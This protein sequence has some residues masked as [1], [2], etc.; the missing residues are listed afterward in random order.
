M[1]CI[2]NWELEKSDYD[3]YH[4]NA[5]WSYLSH[6]TCKMAREKNKPDIIS[7][8]GVVKCD[9][10]FIVVSPPDN[11]GFVSLGGDV[12]CTLGAME[13]AKTI[14]AVVNSF[15]PFTFK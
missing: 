9:V 10:A 4:A 3:L 6:I 2:N 14:I 15:V 7:P 12:V 13:V 5:L 11:N 1:R 8:Q